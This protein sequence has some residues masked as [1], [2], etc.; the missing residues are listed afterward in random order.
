MLSPLR[1]TI[2][3]TLTSKILGVVAILLL[4]PSLSYAESLSE[5][6]EKC[7][8]VSNSLKRLVCY[9][10]LAQR[11]GSMEDSEVKE[12][13]AQRPVVRPLPN[14]GGDDQTLPPAPVTKPQSSFGLERQIK[15][16]NNE[17]ESEIVAVV[18]AVKTNRN[19]KLV[20]TMEDGMVWTQTD[21][22]KIQLK[23]GDTVVISRGLLN[24]FLLKKRGS[25]K[26]IRVRRNK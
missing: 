23:S 24:S 14:A 19:Y 11:A 4:T 1:N 26:S 3:N 5:A 10:Q 2:T 8:L 12:F 20:I 6:M 15:R 18:G 21:T 16:E 9:D 17:Q 22:N 7:R 13:M 25:K